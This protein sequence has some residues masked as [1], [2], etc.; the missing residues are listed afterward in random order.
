MRNVS[1][2]WARKLK[3]FRDNLLNDRVPMVEELT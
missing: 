1:Q 3:F 2:F